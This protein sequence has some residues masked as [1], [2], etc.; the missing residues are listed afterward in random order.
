[1]QTVRTPDDR[2]EGL[3]DFPFA[4]HYADVPAD[5]AE[6]TLRVHFL[7]EGPADAHAPMFRAVAHSVHSLGLAPSLFED[8]LSAFRQ[9]VETRRYATW[10][11]L[12]DYCRRS[13][14][15]VGRLVL[16]IA[17][18][19]GGGVEEASDCLCTA[20]QL[21]NFWQDLAIDWARGR[22]YVPAE[23]H[24]RLRA[25]EADLARGALTEEWKAALGECARRTHA[26]FDAGRPV[27]DLVGGRL[28]LELRFTWLGGVRILERFVAGGCDPWQARPALGPAD[29]PA[30]VWR[31]LRWRKG[32]GRRFT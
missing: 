23:V 12:M 8:L 9:D 13:A 5:T 19:R 27:C 2:F 6:G 11:G 4:P 3:P 7:D 1:M 22:L 24:G 14:N 10:S 30:L 26:L 25:Q 16:Q 28:G 17:G 18:R 31:A 15:P 32:V 20:L 21:T 29:V